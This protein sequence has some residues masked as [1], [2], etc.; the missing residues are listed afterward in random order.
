VRLFYRPPAPAA[1]SLSP[2]QPPPR[3]LPSRRSET[4]LPQGIE[5]ACPYAG[6]VFE[7]TVHLSDTYPYSAP[8]KVVVALDAAGK[9]PLYHPSVNP[10]TGEVCAGLWDKCWVETWWLS[11]FAEHLRSHLVTPMEGGLNAAA[12]VELKGDLALYETKARE[13]CSRLRVR[14]PSGGS[15]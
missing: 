12:G 5:A 9:V 10:V 13:A 2:P 14:A 6:R 3:P 7:L 8:T 11:Q 1:A 4:W 15:A